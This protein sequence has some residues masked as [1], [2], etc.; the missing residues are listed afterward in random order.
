MPAWDNVSLPAAPSTRDYAPPKVDFSTLGNLANTYFQGTQ[1]GRTLQQQSAFKEGLPQDASGNVDWN[2]VTQKMIQLGG[3]QAVPE[4]LKLQLQQ[5]ALKGPP[6]IGGMDDAGSI[7]SARTPAPEVPAAT[8]VPAHGIPSAPTSGAT[9][10]ASN[11]FVPVQNFAETVYPQSD[12]AATNF[13]KMLQSQ[14]LVDQNGNVNAQD[15]RVLKYAQ[16]RNS[17][18]IPNGGTAG[19]APGQTAQAAEPGSTEPIVPRPV[20]T[21]TFTPPQGMTL[22]DADRLSAA[23][24]RNRAVARNYGIAGFNS[25][26]KAYSDQAD[27]LDAQA[28]TI[29]EMYAKGAEPTPGMKDAAASGVRTPLDYSGAQERQKVEAENLKMTPEQKNARASGEGAPMTP[30]QFEAAKEDDKKDVELWNKRYPEIQA[31]GE[32]SKNGL[33][34]AQLMK[35]LTLQPGFYSGPLSEHVQ[36]YQQFKSVFGKNPS[37]ALPAEAFHKVVNDMLI[38]QVKALGKSG[39]GRVLQTEVNTMRQGIASM[40]ITAQSNRALAEIVSRVYQQQADIAEIQRGI[41]APAGQ[42]NVAF[43]GV[44]TKYLEDHPLFTKDELQHPQLIGAPDAPPAS[45]QWSKPQAR[46]WA[47]SVGLNPG[48]PIRIGGQI[49]SVP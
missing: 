8:S 48:D 38:E 3:T 29:R 34:K 28:Q 45:A 15:P 47:K 44:V 32:S 4:F 36:T 9:T 7:P 10:Q 26:A 16:A 25:A 11:T 6:P 43:D 21:Q 24:T 46:A 30:R 2:A 49:M 39:V 33:Q 13:A 20:Q 22:A 18:V 12:V 14:G 1:Q 31:L 37:S 40:G 5:N 23:A 35:N 17:G 42:R 41:K 27:K 19:N